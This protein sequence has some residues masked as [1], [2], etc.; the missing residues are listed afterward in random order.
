MASSCIPAS[1]FVF[2]PGD[3]AEISFVHFHSGIRPGSALFIFTQGSGQD[4]LLVIMLPLQVP[5]YCAHIY[6]F[7]VLGFLISHMLHHNLQWEAWDDARFGGR[8]SLIACVYKKYIICIYLKI[9]HT[10]YSD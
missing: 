1:L 5:T 3:Q 8:T 9:C 10:T 6:C 2:T 7:T 4:Q